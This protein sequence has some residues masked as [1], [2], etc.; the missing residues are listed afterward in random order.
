MH[1]PTVGCVPE[2]KLEPAV[3]LG[4]GIHIPG[5]IKAHAHRHLCTIKG[6]YTC[7]TPFNIPL[8]CG[9]LNLDRG[10]CSYE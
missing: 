2:A 7:I 5:K 8:C 9:D 10:L 6:N 4:I 1:G 3:A